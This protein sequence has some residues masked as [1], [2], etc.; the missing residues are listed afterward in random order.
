[1]SAPNSPPD[2]PPPPPPSGQWAYPT[3]EQGEP[4]KKYVLW[5]VFGAAGCFVAIVVA[6][7]LVT[8]L[9]PN[10]IRAYS[11]GQQS[12]AQ[13]DVESLCTALEAYAAGHG[14]RY[15]ESLEA[16]SEPRL[17][18]DPWGRAYRYEP[19]SAER[20]W[21]DVYSLGRDGLP[22][23]SGADED[24]HPLRLPAGKR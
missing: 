7:L 1:M 22:G 9:V 21:P 16:L 18:H 3:N 17:L 13:V 12:R 2:L 11:R 5:I 20:S 15:P 8:L 23:G 10:L 4:K 14:G 19:P 6:G 24:V